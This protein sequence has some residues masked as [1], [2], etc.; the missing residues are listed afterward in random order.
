LYQ[1][2]G[3]YRYWYGINW[4]AL[5]AML[6]SVTPQLP[7]LVNAV[8]PSLPIG[9]AIYISNMNWYFGLFSSGLVYSVLSLAFPAYETM[10]SAMLDTL[11]GVAEDGDMRHEKKEA[12]VK[13]EEL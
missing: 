10:V 1:P 13:T 2:H 4:R 5:I 3:R 12:S 7:G 11:E 9:G 6:V 8:N